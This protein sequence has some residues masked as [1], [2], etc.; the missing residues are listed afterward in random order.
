MTKLLAILAVFSFFFITVG[1]PNFAVA[2][3]HPK[4]HVVK[5]EYVCPGCGFVSGKAGKCP[6]CPG[7]PT[8]IKVGEYYS[9]SNP[10]FV[11][12]KPGV[13]PD[14]KPL[15]KMT[16]PKKGMMHSMHTM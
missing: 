4:A 6:M 12:S 2:K 11:S 3:K 9:Q 7:N 10:S 16:A 15:V 8:L 5:S 13:G 14:G 1:Q